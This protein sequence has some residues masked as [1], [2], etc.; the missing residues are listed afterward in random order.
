[1]PSYD[2]SCPICNVTRE[3]FKWVSEVD[4]PEVCPRCRERM[5]RAYREMN[6]IGSEFKSGVAFD[7]KAKKD[8][9]YHGGHFD[10]GAGRYFNDKNERK[11]WMKSRGVRELVDAPDKPL[12]LRHVKEET[13][14]AKQGAHP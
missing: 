7:Q 6:F 12:N 11:A 14:I 3:V 5:V 1:M 9:P 4:R 8:I 13:M 10:L 2:Y